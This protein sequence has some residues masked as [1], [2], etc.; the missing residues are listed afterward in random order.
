VTNDNYFIGKSG[1]RC[2]KPRPI[3]KQLTSTAMFHTPGLLRA[4][5]DDYRIK[6]RTRQQAIT[7][8]SNGYGLS[9]EEARGL[10]SGSIHVQIDEAAGTVSYLVP[11]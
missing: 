3:S 2:A 1:R 10:L 8:L 9:A 4:L 6:G 11:N 7:I 5:Q